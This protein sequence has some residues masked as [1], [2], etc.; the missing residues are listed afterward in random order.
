[1]RFGV[2]THLARPQFH[3]ARVFGHSLQYILDIKGDAGLGTFSFMKIG[4]LP[5][6]YDLV[7]ADLQRYRNVLDA[8]DLRELQS[9]D[10][11]HAHGLHVAAFTYLRRVFERRIEVAHG[12]ATAD[13][14]W[15]EAAFR[16]EQFMEGKISRLRAHLPTFLVENRKVYNILSA[17]LH[18]L[19]ED[20]CATGFEA[21]RLGI[22][23]ILDEEIERTERAARIKGASV[24]LQQLAERI[25][26]PR[27]S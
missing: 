17:G 22:T 24:S 13:G 20:E 15:D 8:G 25:S 7:S 19:S 1:M 16:N 26:R 12:A 10:V 3:C 18:E 14:G 5:S 27:G 23:L 6:L 11:C 4:Q 2:Q 21:V 9:A